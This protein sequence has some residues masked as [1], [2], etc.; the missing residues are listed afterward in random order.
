MKKCPYCAE[1]IQNEAVVCR[2]C[3][4]ELPTAKAPQPKKLN[5]LIPG[6]ILL[7]IVILTVGA[8]ALWVRKPA[9][10]PAHPLLYAMDFENQA[11]FSG[12][13]VGG[14][15]EGYFWLENTR[16][17]KYVFEFPSGFLETED[18]Q[19]SDI[20]ISAD[21]EFLSQTRMD[22]S[23][24]CRLRQGEGYRFV[25]NNDGRWTITKSYQ[26]QWVELAQ[27]WSVEIQAD[28]NRL[29]GRCVGDQLTLLVNGVEIGS[30]VDGDMTVGGINLGYNADKAGAGTFD[31]IR[32]EG[33]GKEMTSGS[34]TPASTQPALLHTATPSL[35]PLPSETLTPTLAI[36]PTSTPE[37][38]FYANH[39]EGADAGFED[40]VIYE[41]P[42]LPRH[43]HNNPAY[44][45][46]KNEQKKLVIDSI[47]SEP[48]YALYDLLLPATNQVIS[49]EMEFKGA[50]SGSLSMVCR[51][52]GTGW[53]EIGISS[54]GH[55]QI[56]LAQANGESTEIQRTI[57]AEG[58]S[59]AITPGANRFEVSCLGNELNLTVNGE[60]LGSAEDSTVEEGKVIG[61]VYQEDPAGEV[62]VELTS[63][64]VTDPDGKKHL[65][66]HAEVDSFYF[67]I[68]SFA[69]FTGKPGEL[70]ALLKTEVNMET[71]TGW[72]KIT[73]NRA[74][75]W[76]ALYPQELP[77]NIEVSVDVD[78]ERRD[79]DQGIGLVCRWLDQPSTYSGQ[80]TGGYVL[81]LLQ[82]YVIVTPFSVDEFGNVQSAGTAEFSD[83]TSYVQLLEG[84][85]HHLMARC[86]NELVEFYVDGELVS[87]HS[88]SD[89]PYMGNEKTGSMAGLMFL[90]GGPGSTARMD[91]LTFS[92]GIPLETPRPTSTP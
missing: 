56:T 53:Y 61:L 15:V 19:F 27:G 45:F 59:T 65:D 67:Y 87:R 76:L 32:V 20:E 51:Y 39:F 92:W 40:W 8:Y 71:E 4:K 62:S 28:Q 48:I 10:L 46:A 34:V 44:T 41:I 80:N 31:N 30:A 33:W 37:G 90:S 16:D 18:L 68:W 24:S 69:S 84:T 6:V 17:G 63:F 81:W 54:D 3:G 12:W 89:F 11:T 35:Q 25:I 1:K 70:P 50:G 36:T 82:T 60:L 75:R 78:V 52:S 55:W 58:D 38:L 23:V 5:F 42:F 13:H 9:A 7:G 43:E 85:R 86:W 64:V 29:G 47:T 79:Y 77:Y 26:S 83:H 21:I 49:T 91:N 73:T 57:L 88:T 22:T 14:P 74:M 2:Y 66:L 72:G